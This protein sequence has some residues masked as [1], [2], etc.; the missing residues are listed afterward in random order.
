MK[1]FRLLCIIVVP[2][3][4]NLLAKPVDFRVLINTWG[5]LRDKSTESSLYDRHGFKFEGTY[6]PKNETEEILLRGVAQMKTYSTKESV[7]PWA[8][9]PFYLAVI[10]DGKLVGR[11]I[12]FNKNGGSSFWYREGLQVCPGGPLVEVSENTSL[13]TFHSEPLGDLF[14]EILHDYGR[15]A[16]MVELKI[17]GFVPKAVFFRENQESP[18]LNYAKILDENGINLQIA[19]KIKNPGWYKVKQGSSVYD[20]I[21]AANGVKGKWKG[22]FTIYSETNMLVAR[23]QSIP[24]GL[25]PVS[26]PPNSEISDD[27]ETR[28]VLKEYDSVILK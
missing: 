13:D 24:K 16:P 6:I 7:K 10:E 8:G 4:F 5:S 2:L 22:H 28:V 12:L 3:N 21:K 27:M 26:T 14:N 15:P 23:K 11:V 1:F 17:S 20:L 25:F 19:G 9:R 18:N